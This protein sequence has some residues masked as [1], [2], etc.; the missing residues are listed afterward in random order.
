MVERIE[1]GMDSVNVPAY[2]QLDH[3]TVESVLVV[4]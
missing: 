3:R 2:I 4:D 1:L